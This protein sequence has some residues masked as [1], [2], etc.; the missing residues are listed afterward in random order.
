MGFFKRTFKFLM[1][2]LFI[3]SL[4]LLAQLGLLIYI[5]WRISSGGIYY[6]LLINFLSVITALLIINREFNPAYKISWIIF[7]LI[8]PFAGVLFYLLFG[9]AKIG[10]KRRKLLYQKHNTA[11][12]LLKNEDKVLDE[13]EDELIKRTSQYIT[14]TTGASIYKNTQTTFFSSGEELFVVLLEKLRSAEKFIFLEYFIIESGKMWNSIF[15]ILKEKVNSGV[16]V[17]LMYDDFGCIK[18]IT[19]KMKKEIENAGIK[20]VN[21]NPFRPRLSTFL[22][23]RDHRK[24]A[25]ID[26][27]VAFTGGINIADEYINAKRMFGYWEDSGIMVE[28]DAV[29]TFTVSFLEMWHL[30][31][32]EE[33]DFEKYRP[34]LL[35]QHDGYVQPFTDGPLTPHLVTENTYLNIINNAKKYVYITTPYL[36]IDNE[37]AT[38]LK[39]AA[40]SGVDVRIVTPG[41]PDKKLV[42]IVTQSY[43]KELLLHGVKI[44]QYIPGFLHSKSIV[45]DG[46]VGVVGTAN[47]DY[48]S[49]YLHYENSCYMYKSQAVR[50]LAKYYEKIL[51]NSK[52][53]TFVDY[54]NIPLWKKIL[55]FFL[56]AVSPL[57]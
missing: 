26:G 54:K 44:Y 57:M 17:R 31:K 4:L 51:D 38:A 22:N 16:E 35:C 56:R 7:V 37:M 30:E 9:R 28:G 14:N 40:M 52:Q 42:F 11:S 29:W 45:S 47:F 43:Y 25:I 49:L 8:I 50:D 23:Y 53:I 15:D 20:V 1:S 3:V 10:R 12:L 39:N 55:A 19:R 18:R 21:F 5:V 32:D 24:L 33:V 2:R 34:T 13:I 6:Y 36:I 27:N 46:E 41:I 48:R